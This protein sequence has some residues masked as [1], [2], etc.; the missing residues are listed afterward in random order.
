M[1]ARKQCFLTVY[2]LHIHHGYCFGC[3]SSYFL[4]FVTFGPTSPASQY[5]IYGKRSL[6]HLGYGRPY[7]NTVA[8]L[9]DAHRQRCHV[10]CNCT[11]CIL[12]W[13]SARGMCSMNTSSYLLYSFLVLLH[14][15]ALDVTDVVV[16]WR[17][18]NVTGQVLFLMC[19]SWSGSYWN[20]LH[21][22]AVQSVTRVRENLLKPV[23]CHF[24][25]RYAVRIANLKVRI[26]HGYW[27]HGS[28]TWAIAPSV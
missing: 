20:L 19:R 17:L 24:N 22:I 21:F 6:P 9:F 5:S 14:C 13:R 18:W 8:A 4:L 1:T 3:F 12:A 7:T 27:A 10:D 26:G 11:A 28:E 2:V 23:S 25:W 15:A 16:C